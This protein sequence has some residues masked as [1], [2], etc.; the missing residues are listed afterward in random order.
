MTIPVDLI[1]NFDF[2]YLFFEKLDRHLACNTSITVILAVGIG[3]A[4]GYWA[5]AKEKQQQLSKCNCKRIRGF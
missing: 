3:T 4:R 1:K 2:T 5:G